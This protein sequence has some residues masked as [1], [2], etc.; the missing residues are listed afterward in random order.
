MITKISNEVIAELAASS[1]YKERFIAEY[2]LLKQKHEKLKAFNTK[3]EAAEL[4]KGMDNGVD[5]PLH[6]CP[7]SLLRGQQK[8]M[9][10][11]L[12]ILEVRAV[13]EGIDLKKAIEDLA[14]ESI[15]RAS[16]NC[17]GEEAKCCC[18]SEKTP[19][20]EEGISETSESLPDGVM[21][22][23]RTIAML[24]SAIHCETSGEDCKEA[25]C[26]MYGARLDGTKCCLWGEPESYKSSLYHLKK[27]AGLE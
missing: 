25:A 10:E 22:L 23:E 15:C 2:I 9:G 21:G 19:P 1:S 3:I 11:Y 20:C 6:D 13:I 12:H 4:T 26:P 14:R 27:Y 8:V 7:A 5:E 24:E 16:E 18:Q 17:S